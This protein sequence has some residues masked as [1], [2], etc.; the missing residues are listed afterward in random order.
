MSP[1]SLV[2]GAAALK[3][4]RTRSGMA[5]A[6]PATVVTGRQGRGW[7][8]TR[9]SWR[10]SPADQL[11]AHVHA[12]ADELGVHPP[13]AVGAVGVGEDLPDE[14]LQPLLALCGRRLGSVAP[15]VEPRPRHV[16][17][18]AHLG[19]RV[20]GLLGVDEPV[21]AAHRC[22]RAKKAAAFPRNSAFIRSSRTSFSSSRSRAR[23]ESASGGSSS[24]C[25]A[26]YLLTQLPSVPSFTWISRATSAT[27]R[28]VSITIFTASSLNSGEK[29]LRDSGILRPSVPVQTL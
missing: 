25:S 2:P 11:I 18:L 19:D 29:L 7:Q 4:R 23:S 26:R 27:G 9:P 20:V 15:F 22:S 3:S 28:D 21:L 10:I 1:T 17:P 13:V 24:T 8:A 12:H 5:S 16:N 14:D 6:S